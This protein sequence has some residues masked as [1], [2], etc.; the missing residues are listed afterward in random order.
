MPLSF[1][2]LAPLVWM[3]TTCALAASAPP[4]RPSAWFEPLDAGNSTWIV[5]APG[6]EAELSADAFRLKGRAGDVL[7]VRLIGASKSAIVRGEQ[8]LAARS[9]YFHGNDPLKWGGAIA[10]FTRART[11][12]VYPG[13]DAVYYQ[14]SHGLEADFI[15]SAGSDYRRIQLQFVDRRIALDARG[16]LYD[17]A[18]GDILMAAPSAYEIGVHEN[19]TLVRSR[20]KIVAANRASFEVDRIDSSRTLVIDPILVYATY[21]GGSGS[22]TITAIERGSDGRVYVAGYTTSVDLPR[23]VS[24][25]SLLIR[26]V[27]LPLP[28]TFVVCYSPDGSTLAYA[29]YVGGDG[30]D[31]ATSLAVDPQGRATVVGYSGSANFPTT[32]AAFST[33][34]AG[35]DAF[36]Y[37]LSADGSALEYSTFLKVISPT[38]GYLANNPLTFLVGVDAS[39]AATI[40]GNAVTFTPGGCCSTDTVIGVT[41]TAGAYQAQVAGGSDVFLMRLSPD[42]TSLQWATYYGG[43]QN[44]ALTG[45]TL[46]ASG[47]VLVTGTTTSNDL[48]LA[49]PFQAAPPTVYGTTPVF[50]G[51]NAG[52]F[53]K[54]SSDGTAL[55]AASYFG[56]QNNNT[57]LSS[58]A[59][60]NT[61]AIY[62]AGSSPVSAAPGVTDVPG[63]TSVYAPQ[64]PA[65]IVKLD[66]TG[67]ATKYMW[68]YS[69][70]TAGVVTRIRVNASQG[71]CILTDF[72]AVPMV[73]GALPANPGYPGVGFACFAAD[74]KT[75]QFA[76][77]P[78]ASG[79]GPSSAPIDFAIA[80]NG[81]LIAATNQV[82]GAPTTANAPQPAA[83]SGSNGYVF[84][85][86][87]E[88]P[89]PQLYY[90]S[91]E[92]VFTP[93]SS[94]GATTLTLLGSNFADGESVLWAGKPVT[95]SNPGG[96]FSAT[97]ISEELSSATL[98]AL[99]KGDV[100]IQVSMP[101]PGGGV[102]SP[103]TIKY[104]NP[105]PTSISINPQTLP[106][107]S[108]P[109]TF[110]VTGTLTPDCSITW[111]G[112]S[113]SVSSGPAAFQ[114]TVPAAAFTVPGNFVVV[115]SNPAPGGGSAAAYVS[116]T[117]NG[118]P[119]PVVT[120]PVAVGLGQGGA[121][122]NLN[123][124]FAPDD[125]VV[126]WNG[127][128]RPTSR[129]NSTTLQFILSQ[130]DLQQMGSAQVQIGSGGVLG[131]AVTAYVGLAVSNADVHGDP[132][133]GQAYFASAGTG[134]VMQALV[135]VAV[136]TGNIVRSLDMGVPIQSMFMTD[137]NDYLWVTTSDGR[138]RRVNVDTFAVDMTA[139]VPTTQSSATVAA[140]VLAA[141]PVAGS[142]ST[143]V[144]TGAD[145]VIRIFDGSKQRGFSSADLYPTV[146][147]SLTPVFAT[148]DVVWAIV[149]TYASTCML[150]LT[151]DYTGFSSFAQ[152]CNN[153]FNGPWD[154]PSPEVKLDAG[155]T[156]FQS[157]SET[158]VWSSPRGGYVDF[159]KR[160]II[161]EF[162]QQVGQ[163]GSTYSYVSSL[164]IYDL[165]SEAQLAIVPAAGLLPSG[166]FVPYSESQ[167]LF[168]VS[169][170]LLLLDL[171]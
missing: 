12:A 119:A 69:S 105:A 3:A 39:G 82:A 7:N 126:V 100:Q 14:G 99:P 114:F 25:D 91:P 132:A 9:F 155:V 144:A 53:V 92:L 110:T 162:N 45:M 138:I 66:S 21:L 171:P 113:Q 166:S 52:F 44:E 59:L 57:T 19:R 97:S 42:G 148:P 143:I 121:T 4:P 85:I 117:A 34:F 73:R 6:A 133:R 70:L 41:A 153:G 8:A 87:S 104:V 152:T 116:V 160:R 94:S 83:A 81:T 72:G 15:A 127:S 47:N 136:P 80:P 55:T 147:A 130:N 13:I 20:F 88:N 75:L 103:V 10:H 115:A 112:V 140:T 48:P 167:A 125:A 86:Q 149:G 22:D 60:D 54:L 98:A 36:A 38:W 124:N 65:V 96:Y 76:T 120:G 18:S 141:I 109:T 11:V 2:V 122:Q 56:G 61:G 31:L 26:P 123:V 51:A 90:V 84:E 95:L 169:N 63:P 32:P 156:Y 27:T 134:G 151:Y 17:K 93:T 157:G 1:R 29:V 168:N 35:R 159:A 163:P 150:R 24:L 74:G 78:P 37:R 111:N 108:G 89:A 28:E 33:T 40:G 77:L 106:V 170:T 68:A 101:G 79:S 50:S 30:G 102:S 62:L 67:R 46:D 137:D 128:D 154:L 129:L 71:P 146:P 16:N 118:L 131:P 139:M 58:V 135:A 64:S 49:H 145:G 23:A 164:P 5:R 43:S 165:D 161:G 107:G 142:S 158:L